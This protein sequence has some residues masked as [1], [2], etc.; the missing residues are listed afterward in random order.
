ME[1][2]LG[3]SSSL[4]V[5]PTP[6]A[7]LLKPRPLAGRLAA[8]PVGDGQAGRDGQREARLVDE[9][10]EGSGRRRR[11]RVTPPAVMLPAWTWPWS[12]SQPTSPSGRSASGAACWA[13]NWSPAPRKRARAGKPGPLAFG[14]DVFVLEP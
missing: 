2:V 14:F 11:V 5:S 13:C 12:S 9:A 3:R 8:T 10:G 7:S 6:S 4:V 1:F